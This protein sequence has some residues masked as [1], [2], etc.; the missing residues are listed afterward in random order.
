MADISK[1]KAAGFAKNNDIE[2]ASIAKLRDILDKKHVKAELQSNDKWPNTDGYLTLTNEDDIQIGKLEVQVKTLPDEKV[3]RPVYQCSRELLAYAY[4]SNSLPVLLIVVNANTETAYW[5]HLS[6]PFV[7]EIAAAME[8]KTVSVAFSISNRI[9]RNNKEYVAQWQEICKDHQHKL[10]HFADTKAELEDVTRK[11]A[12]LRDELDYDQNAIVHEAIRLHTFITKYNELLNGEFET[13]KQVQF[14]GY[15]RVGVAYTNYEPGSV[16]YILYP[17]AIGDADALVKRLPKGVEFEGEFRLHGYLS[18]NPF[19]EDPVR[20]AATSI[21]EL[22]MRTIKKPLIELVNETLAE[23]CLIKII[24][25]IHDLAGFPLKKQYNLDTMLTRLHILFPLVYE[26]ISD[27]STE[28]YNFMLNTNVISTLVHAENVHWHFAKAVRMYRKGNLPAR[29]I[30]FDDMWG[31]NGDYLKASIRF[32]QGG[33]QRNI[34]RPY[35]DVD[36]TGNPAYKLFNLEDFTADQLT[37]MVTAIYK[38]VPDLFDEYIAVFFPPLSGKV[39]FF[40]ELSL[41][42]INVTTGVHAGVEVF[43][44]ASDAMKEPKIA[45]FT[46]GVNSPV[47]WSTQAEAFEK[48][49]VFEGNVYKLKHSRQSALVR[50][51][52]GLI[53]KNILQDYVVKR[54]EKYF[55]NLLKEMV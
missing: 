49:I 14:P 11:L 38:R 55:E 32:L 52:E 30:V 10:I 26:L 34:R 45:S 47:T 5:L 39:K 42:I 27:K 6:R 33:S 44:F 43:N 9:T 1:F 37:R 3:D 29:N 54:L 48:G 13:I 2:E 25:Y 40:D 7:A 46:N 19:A 41:L 50:L 31:V 53:L 4:E 24:D 20:F 17:V 12:A 15:V 16:E 22:A 21:I 36:F 51:W 35:D 8:G 23:E 18:K 28:G